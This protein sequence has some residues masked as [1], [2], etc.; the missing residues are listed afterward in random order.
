MYCNYLLLFCGYHFPSN[1]GI[2]WWTELIH[3]TTTIPHMAE[4][5]ALY[6]TGITKANRQEFLHF[7]VTNP[8]LLSS[9][10]IL[11][12]FQS[13]MIQGLFFLLAKVNFFLYAMNP[14]QSCHFRTRHYQL[15]SFVF[16][17]LPWI[18]SFSSVFKHFHFS[19]FWR[20]QQTNTPLFLI[21]I[22]T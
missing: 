15:P 2:F 4:K 11:S 8:T 21:S 10:P 3:T 9:V 16:Q 6:F 1:N 22:G 17:I 13:I 12:S 18:G 5:C 14:I 7:L 20:K 19:P